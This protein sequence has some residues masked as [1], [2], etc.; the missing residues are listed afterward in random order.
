MLYL[1]LDCIEDI[2]DDVGVVKKEIEVLSGFSGPWHW[3]SQVPIGT[4]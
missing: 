1:I 3:L 2:V 4:H